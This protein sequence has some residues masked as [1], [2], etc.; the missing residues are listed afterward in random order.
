MTINPQKIIGNTA[1]KFDYKES[2]F[3]YSLEKITVLLNRVC[4]AERK[5]KEN[6]ITESGL[7]R[8]INRYKPLNFLSE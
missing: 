7:Y 3:K 5:A 2:K 1:D 4:L 6:I 8:K